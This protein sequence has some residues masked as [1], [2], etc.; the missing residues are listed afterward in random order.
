MGFLGNPI[1]PNLSQNILSSGLGYLTLL[2]FGSCIGNIGLAR[3]GW[4]WVWLGWV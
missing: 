4:V 2:G 1:L 3:L